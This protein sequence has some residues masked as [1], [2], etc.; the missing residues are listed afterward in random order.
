MQ[1]EDIEAALPERMSRYLML[2]AEYTVEGI[3]DDSPANRFC[4]LCQQGMKPLDSI[5][6]ADPDKLEHRLV[7]FEA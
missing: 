6:V 5:T 4:C 1:D 3:V 2:V 7:V